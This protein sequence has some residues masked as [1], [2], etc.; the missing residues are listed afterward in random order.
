MGVVLDHLIRHMSCDGLERRKGRLSLDHDRI[1][2]VAKIVDSR[3]D[4]G[5]LLRRSPRLLPRPH[6]LRREARW[7]PM[8]PTSSKIFPTNERRSHVPEDRQCHAL[9]YLQKCRCATRARR[10]VR[11]NQ[12]ILFQRTEGAGFDWGDWTMLDDLNAIGFECGNPARMIGQ[13]TDA[14]NAEVE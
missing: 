10:L 12:D 3:L 2:M 4:A 9:L 11:F 5:S 6:G 7:C 13:Q 1:G 14:A 8:T